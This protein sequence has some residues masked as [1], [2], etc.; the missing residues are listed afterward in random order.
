M[1]RKGA[2]PRPFEGRYDVTLATAIVALV[3]FI[4][5]STAYVMFSRQVQADLHASQ[6][7]AE[8]V[9]GLS[10]AGMRSAR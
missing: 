1:A 9:A 2:C 3:P 7:G 10:I 8:I 5:V 4:V 6:L